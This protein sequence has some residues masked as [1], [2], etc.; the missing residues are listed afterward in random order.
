MSRNKLIEIIQ[1]DIILDKDDFTSRIG[2]TGN[3]PVPV[4]INMGEV[5]RRVDMRVTHEEAG[6][7]IVNQVVLTGLSSVLIVA[8][9][10]DV[11]VLLCHFLHPGYISGHDHGIF[12]EGQSCY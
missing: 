9:D 8:D 10:T 11:I 5:I 2:V 12:S 3:D 6:T 7:M 4:E 1:A